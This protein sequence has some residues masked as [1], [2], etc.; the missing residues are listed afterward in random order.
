[1]CTNVKINPTIASKPHF[2]TNVPRILND[3][4]TSSFHF[5]KNKIIYGIAL[6]CAALISLF[7]IRYAFSRLMKKICQAFML[8]AECVG[9]VWII[10]K[11]DQR[12]EIV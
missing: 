10:M 7:V 8:I 12:F 2:S 4:E 5:V 3:K 11:L 1:M 9:L 6:Q